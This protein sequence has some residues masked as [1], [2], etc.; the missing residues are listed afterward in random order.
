MVDQYIIN[1]I[2]LYNIHPVANMMKY[3]IKRYKNLW[4]DEFTFSKF[5]ILNSHFCWKCHTYI[6]IVIL[7]C[8]DKIFCESCWMQ[9]KYDDVIMIY[10]GMYLLEI[11]LE[12]QNKKIISNI[13]KNNY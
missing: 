8:A 4:I 11:K 2:M 12:E 7:L 10:T 9:T 3:M 13:M 5:I 6:E 1:K